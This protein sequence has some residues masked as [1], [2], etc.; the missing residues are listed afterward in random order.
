MESTVS[1]VR[2]EDLES[3]VLRAVELLGGMERFVKGGDVVL[4][5]PN[6]VD[7]RDP[8]TGETVHPEVIKALI[9]LAFD[10]GAGR[11]IAGEGPTL[12][13]RSLNRPLHRE[14]K[15]I[16]EKEGAEMINFEEHPFVKVRV[17]NPVCFSEVRVPKVLLEC[18]VF[19]N[20]PALKTHHLVGVTVALKNLYGVLPL[21]YKR[22]YHTLDRTEEIIVDLNIARRSDLTVVDGTY[23]THHLPPLERLTL[24]LTIV[25]NKPVAVDAVSAKIL[26]LDP[27]KIRILKWA[28]EKGL[29]T[30]DLNRIRIL[31]LSIREAFREKATTIVDIVNYLYDGMIVLVN[32]G[33]CTGC[34]C[35]LGT[36][37]CMD[38]DSSTLKRP[39]YILCGPNAEPPKDVDVIFC[40]ECLRLKYEKSSRGILVPGCPSA[41][42]EFR[43][44]LSMFNLHS[45]GVLSRRV[46]RMYLKGPIIKA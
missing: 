42:E 4:I 2:G 26:G 3:R 22:R 41:L 5:K 45:S 7:G 18:E 27:D 17:K 1:I 29:D 9:R 46:L 35:R 43:E 32:G 15:R 6:L 16:A 34:F 13:V 33:A 28:E 23:A 14:V 8:E 36:E 44:G 25:G 24:N 37:L 31:G 20:V 30:F 21:E 11:V 38:Y 39:L 40:G 10:A 12:Y 19:I